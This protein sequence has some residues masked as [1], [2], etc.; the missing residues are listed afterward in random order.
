MKTKLF[1]ALSLWFICL[2]I[3]LELGFMA[4]SAT[5]T[6]ANFVGLILLLSFGFTSAKTHCFTNIK[7]KKK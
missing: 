1:I 3:V 2:V 6:L 7:I 5:D 4:M